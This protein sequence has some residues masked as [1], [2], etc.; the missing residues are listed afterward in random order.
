M[1][2]GCDEGGQHIANVTH[3]D[4]TAKE[5]GAACARRSEHKKLCE[6]RRGVRYSYSFTPTALGIGVSISCHCGQEKDITGYDSGG[7]DP[8]AG[9]FVSMGP[10]E[11]VEKRKAKAKNPK[12][13]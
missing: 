11:T 2:F 13:S 6:D 12:D 3:F 1:M 4:L 10:P 9:F 5:A 8:S 7:S